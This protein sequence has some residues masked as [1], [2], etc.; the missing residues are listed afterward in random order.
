MNLLDASAMS[1]VQ[2]WEVHRQ[3]RPARLDD[4]L[5]VQGGFDETQLSR[6]RRR[7]RNRV[8]DR[9]CG[10]R[11]GGALGPVNRYVEAEHGEIYL[12]SRTAATKGFRFSTAVRGR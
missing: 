10:A 5:L 8:L 7:D 9:S 12:H 11:S 6:C 4:E 3:F 1:A 2:R